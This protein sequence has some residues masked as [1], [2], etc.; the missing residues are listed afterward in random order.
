MQG[1]K[2]NYESLAATSRQ[3][4]LKRFSI[5]YCQYISTGWINHH[6]VITECCNRRHYN[7]SKV[8]SHVIHA[9]ANF[10]LFQMVAN[11]EPLRTFKELL[12]IGITNRSAMVFSQYQAKFKV[13]WI[14]IK[15][16]SSTRVFSR[17][18]WRWSQ[19]RQNPPAPSSPPPRRRRPGCPASQEQKAPP[20]FQMMIYLRKFGQELFLNVWD[21]EKAA[22]HR[23]LSQSLVLTLLSNLEKYSLKPGFV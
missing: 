2:L 6:N 14:R 17:Y 21:Q 5:L 4:I 11:Y 1:R 22:V 3:L 23:G 9:H 19:G 8:E 10:N 13:A 15:R 16:Q 12:E 20:V 7:L 18:Q